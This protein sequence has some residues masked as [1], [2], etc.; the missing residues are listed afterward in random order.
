MWSDW[1]VFCEYGFSMCALWCPLATPTVL[2]EFLL[3]F[4]WGISSWLLQQSTATAPY[5]GR[6]HP[7]WPWIWSS[8]SRPSCAHA[9]TA[10]WMWGCSSQPPPDL[11]RGVARLSHCPWPR[12]WGSSSWPPPD[13]R[14]GVATLSRPPL[15]LGMGKVLSS[16]LLHSP[17]QPPRF[18]MVHLDND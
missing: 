10:P 12:T 16:T 13:L 17:S 2:L 9:A 3:P 14:C 8:S 11:G 6:G 5:L 4:T 1:L 15:T 7:S 18:C